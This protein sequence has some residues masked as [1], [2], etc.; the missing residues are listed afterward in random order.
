MS[1]YIKYFE[2]ENPSMSFFINDEE[3]GEK[4]EEIW[5]VIKN[6]S[7]IKFHREPV[8][9]YKYLKTK[10]KEYDGAIKTNFLGNDMPKEN[11][12]YTCI[13][14]ITVDSV[15][16]IDEKYSQQVYL[17]EC[18]YRIKKTQMSTFINTELVPD[19]DSDDDYD[20]NSDYDSGGDSDS[21]SDSDSD[22]K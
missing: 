5:D 22:C 17:E 6:K 13:A 2:H 8:Y 18:K 11:I 14:C 1:R 4:Y 16:K 21:G 10:V 20:D 12:H 7:E 9:E 15:V 19:L 3:M